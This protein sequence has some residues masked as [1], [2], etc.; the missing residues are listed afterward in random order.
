MLCHQ[1]QS[2]L[3]HEL[4][5]SQRRAQLLARQPEQINRCLHRRQRHPSRAAA[6]RLGVELERSSGDNAQRAF[7]AHKQVA[8][9]VARVVFAQA[10]QI[11]PDFALRRNY[12]Q[13]QTQLAR[14]AIAQHLRA[15]RIG[16]QV[17]AYGATA[18]RGHA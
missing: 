13:P 11:A 1:R 4:K 3:P 16:G 6:A 10:A 7:A 9:I 5:C 17:A 8:Q 12:L 15:A 14:I 18:L 2:V